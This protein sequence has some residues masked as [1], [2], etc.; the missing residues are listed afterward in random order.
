MTHTLQKQLTFLGVV[1][2]LSGAL[3]WNSG[4]LRAQ[5]GP[6]GRGLGMRAPRIPLTRDQAAKNFMTL[7]EAVE[8]GGVRNGAIERDSGLMSSISRSSE[9]EEILFLI[10]NMVV[11][12]KQPDQV[13]QV[14]SEDAERAVVTVET[15]APTLKSRPLVL[16]KEGDSWGVDVAETWAK[17]NGFE[18]AAKTEAIAQIS[19]QVSNRRENMRRSSC[20]SNLK[21]IALGLM[22]YSMD[23][24]DRLPPAKPWIDVVL[25]YIKSQQ[26]F[27][28]P[29]VTD[30]KGYGY[31][32]NSKL[33][34]KSMARI[35]DTSATTTFY[36]TTVLKRNAYGM[37]E[38]RANRHF[39]GA[40]F[41]FVDGHVKWYAASESP[42][43]NLGP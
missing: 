38:N 25:P 12:R 20:Q 10:E 41:A 8:Q 34:N 24:D 21:Q 6:G 11:Q 18:G 17:W 36:E 3:A 23:Y 43:F 19:G 28:C 29:S 39:G 14:E 27:T 30:P 9:K 37:G 33:S 13:V 7:L 40:N 16:V 5:D 26:L 32:Y 22:Q 1:T 35:R 31:A 15:V 2:V 42:S 4:A